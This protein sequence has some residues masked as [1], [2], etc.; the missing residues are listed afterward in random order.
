[1]RAIFII[2]QN[3]NHQKIISKGGGASEWLF[4]LTA[5][6]LSQI[7]GNEIIIYNKDETEQILDGIQYKYYANVE[8]IKTIQNETVIMQRE[9]LT[10]KIIHEINPNNKYYCWCHDHYSNKYQSTNKPSMINEYFSKNNIQVICISKFQKRIYRAKLPRVTI[11]LIYNAIFKEYYPK[12]SNINYNKD[13][14][15][16]ASNWEKRLDV[17]LRGCRNYHNKNPN[18]RV[19]LLKPAYVKDDGD[20]W[21][22]RFP[23]IEIKGCVKDKTEYSKLIQGC[24]GVF[25]T[26]FPETF[27]CVFAEALHLGV[28]VIG[29]NSI[30]T[31]YKEF[32]PS[33]LLCNF[34]NADKIAAKIEEIYNNR[35]NVKLDDKF[36]ADQVIQEWMKLLKQ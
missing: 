12:L 5:Y 3:S 10:L 33:N 11:H 9:L 27:G 21:K 28:P 31:G 6:K 36:Y 30:E 17:V 32:I 25:G 13:V 26:H 8:I 20:D 23:F 18:F 22:R 1:M 35:P 2:N 7:E 34:N 29:D 4:F 16:F 24:L 15:L 14:M 19:Y